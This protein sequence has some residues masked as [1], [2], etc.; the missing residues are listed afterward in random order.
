VAVAGDR[1]ITKW[2]IEYFLWNVDG[3]PREGPGGWL[4]GKWRPLL[5]L[6]GSGFLT[7]REWAEH[8]PPEIALIALIHFVFLLIV[9]ALIVHAV[10]WLGRQGKKVNR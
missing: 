9:L 6:I 7:W 5:A 4:L 3:T 10:R 8:H 1:K 2:F